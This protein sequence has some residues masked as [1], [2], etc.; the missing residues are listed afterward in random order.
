MKKH[1]LT[2]ALAVVTMAASAQNSALYKIDEL[3]QKG[4]L[5]AAAALCDEAIANPKTTKFQAKCSS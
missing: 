3:I 5:V 1:L 2:L 4:D